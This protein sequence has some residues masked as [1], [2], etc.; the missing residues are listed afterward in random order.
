[1]A[2]VNG[3]TYLITGANRGMGKALLTTF[4]SRSDATV[5]AAVRE[6]S[7]I[8]AM[9]LSS[10]QVGQGS[11]LI[12][13]KIDS[14]SE[15]DAIAAVETL[16]SR[17][18]ITRLDTVI[19]NAGIGT[20]YGPAISTTA[21]QLQEHITVNAI[22]P[23]LLFQAVNPLLEKSP[24]P[25]FIVIGSPNGSIGG[26]ENYPYPM[27]AYGAS[28]AIAHYLIRKIHLEHEGLIA[29]A[30]DPGYVGTLI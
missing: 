28:K 19:A 7:S 29:F 23:L 16:Q 2:S 13:V 12:T 15:T 26:M 9:A 3:Q 10:L 22:G 25:K 18:G 17:Y 5:I 11:R 27:F 21:A 8:S 24:R 6:P 14:S 4:L 30:I 20:Y 1:M